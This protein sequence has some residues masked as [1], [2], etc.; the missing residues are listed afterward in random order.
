MTPR[1][2]RTP[3]LET[4]RIRRLYDDEARKYDRQIAFFEK[5][6]FGHGREWACSQARGEVLEIAVG[7]GRNLMHYPPELHVIGIE[8]SPAML[9]IAQR[10]ARELGRQ[11]DLRLG[12]AQALDFPAERFD[13]VVCTLSLCTIPDDR[14]AVAEVRR[15][16]RP[17][18][19]FLLLEHVRSP[20]L[21]VRAG[22]RVLEPLFLRFEGDHLL[23]EPVEH[24]RALG[25]EIER[26]E[27]SKWGI[28]ERV[29]ARKPAT[30]QAAA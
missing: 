20:A 10:R 22:Q 24:L 12:D 21:A 8:L 23:R 29:A 5:I 11:A 25:F 1:S 30:A 16:L 14:A 4:E 17:G 6:L 27:R 13:T 15:V 19:R 2:G 9:E 3:A 26:R 28:V 7:T 18:G